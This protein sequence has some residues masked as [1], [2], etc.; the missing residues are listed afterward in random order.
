MIETTIRVEVKPSE[1]YVFVA[2]VTN[3]N[4]YELVYREN[5]IDCTT[6][7]F[8]GLMEMEAVANAMLKAV[9]C[10]RS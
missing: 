2:Q 3:N 6:I 4:F 10:A 5:D 9:E 1:D 7:S 8:G